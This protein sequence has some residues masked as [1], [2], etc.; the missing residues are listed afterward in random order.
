M[1]RVRLEIFPVTDDITSSQTLM[2]V[3]FVVYFSPLPGK[4]VCYGHLGCFSNDK[5]WAGM[6]QR[7]LKIFPW[8]PEDIDTRFL[9]YTN[10]NPNNYQVSVGMEC[11]RWMTKSSG[12]HEAQSSDAS[13][14]QEGKD[15]FNRGRTRLLF[16]DPPFSRENTCPVPRPSLE[17]LL[18]CS[19]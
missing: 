9:L 16:L 12:R 14:P 7:P 2:L 5:P 3:L 11:L 6:L 18:V 17:L 8:S 1:A 4:E 13:S 15:N 19:G 10:E